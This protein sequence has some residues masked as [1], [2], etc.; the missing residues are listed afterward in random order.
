MRKKTEGR[1]GAPRRGEEDGGCQGRGR[2]KWR[3]LAAGFGRKARVATET[4]GSGRPRPGGNGSRWS[5]TAEGGQG[6]GRQGAPKARVTP[7]GSARPMGGDG[8]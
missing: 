7:M 2:S 8:T 1:K 6:R 5:M 3:R 4:S